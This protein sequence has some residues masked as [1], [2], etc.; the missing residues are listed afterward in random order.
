MKTLRKQRT[1]ARPAEVTGFGYWSGKNVRVEFRPASAN[2]GITFVRGDLD[3]P[4]RIP[5]AV[6][7]R[8]EVPRRTALAAD[9][10]Q[11]EM[12]EHILAAVYGLCIDNCEIWVDGHEM[13]GCD[14]S[15]QPFVA[16][17]DAAGIVEQP[18]IRQRLVV[19]DITRVGDDDCWI[20]ARPLPTG[21]LSLKY[22]LDY[23]QNNPIGKQAIEVLLN[24]ASFRQELAPARTFILQ[25]EAD[26]LRQRGLGTRV[27]NKDLLVFGP[28]GVIENELRYE[29]ECVRHKALDLLGDLSLAGCD[30][31]G[32]FIAHKSGH[33]LNAELV[34][35]LLKEGQMEQGLRRTG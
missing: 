32:Q 20:E 28:D 21:R 14:G 8:I 11:V 23:G 22:K 17:L 19:A 30:L 1:I 24:T 13:P 26:W 4:R 29:N 33:R 5:A 18:A 25:E 31:A 6:E 35:V 15:A 16:A 9:G 34:K 27:T 2:S 7:H 12:V 10:S 3:R